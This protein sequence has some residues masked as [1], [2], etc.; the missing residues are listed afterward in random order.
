MTS[1]TVTHWKSRLTAVAA[2]VL[3]GLAVWVLATV[4]LGGAPRS[5]AVGSTASQPIAAPW[6]ATVVAGVSLAAWAL[7]AVL[8]RF[9]ARPRTVWTI[10]AGAVFVLSLA[11]P[12][13]GAGISTANRIMLTLMHLTVAA[14]LIPLLA[15]TS[16]QQPK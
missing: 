1:L 7:L 10:V 6:V 4:A 14:L 8:E 15:R 9:V 12:W 16:E 13:Q 2:A 3:G 11:A 5:P